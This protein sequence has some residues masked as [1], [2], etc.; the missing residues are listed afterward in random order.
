MPQVL[1]PRTRYQK[2]SPASGFALILYPKIG[3]LDGRHAHNA[4]LQELPDPVTKV[5]WD[6][7][8]MVSPETADTLHISNN[9]IITVK[10]GDRSVTLP[11]YTMPG[12]AKYA[13]RRGRSVASFQ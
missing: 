12:H 8:A 5:T 2:L 3:M 4:W 1:R 13:I 7:Y 6:N 10:V 9:E 11:C